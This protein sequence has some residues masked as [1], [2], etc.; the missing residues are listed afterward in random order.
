[1]RVLRF[2]FR[3]VKL[4]FALSLLTAELVVWI[5]AA[6]RAVLSLAAQSM[7][8]AFRLRTRTLRCPRGHVIPVHSETYDVECGSCGYVYQGSLLRCPNPECLAATS[9]FV[10]CPECGLSTNNPFRVRIP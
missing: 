9:P 6:V 1:M 5:A 3:L 2:L 4:L 10:A 8:I 7:A